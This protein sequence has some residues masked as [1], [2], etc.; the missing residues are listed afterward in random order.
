MLFR[1]MFGK[2]NKNC[3]YFATSGSGKTAVI[4]FQNGLWKN[5]VLS[6]GKMN[7]YSASEGKANYYRI[8]NRSGSIKYYINNR[9]LREFKSV[10]DVRYPYF[11]FFISGSGIVVY[12][13]F[14]IMGTDG[15][16]YPVK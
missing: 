8:E 16:N 7:A 4:N 13:D 9:L 6:F 14:N 12:D 5:Y 10:Y 11:G 2:D 1:S 15:L 3:Y